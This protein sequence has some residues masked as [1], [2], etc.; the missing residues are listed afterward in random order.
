MAACAVHCMV[1]HDVQV[2]SLLDAEHAEKKRL[3]LLVD[4]RVVL[5]TVLEKMM[6]DKFMYGLRPPPPPPL[7]FLRPRIR[8]DRTTCS[9][10][11]GCGLGAL[12]LQYS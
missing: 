9:A 6:D 1:R 11:A 8:E 2:S 10:Y 4:D 12:F 3:G 5:E 7:L